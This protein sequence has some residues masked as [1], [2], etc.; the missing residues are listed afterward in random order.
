M[1]T[2]KIQVL[3]SLGAPVD[4][5]LKNEGEAADA[6]ATGERFDKI[7]KSLGNYP[8]AD[9]VKDIEPNKYYEFGVVDSL[10]VNLISADDDG[11]LH[12]YCF[13]F[14]P[15]ESFTEFT[16]TPDVKWATQTQIVAGKT[17]QVSILRGIGVMVCA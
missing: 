17:H 7:E 1:A 14:I 15:S 13:E 11:K 3:G 5:T 6:K 10:S 16:V 12:E 4:A 2:P 8:I 9:G